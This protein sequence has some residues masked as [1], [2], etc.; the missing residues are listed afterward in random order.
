MLIIL[1][2]GLFLSLTKDLVLT[3]CI[4]FIHLN[5]LSKICTE[6][7]FK[8]LAYCGGPEVICKKLNETII[9]P[10]VKYCKKED[11]SLEVNLQPS[12]QLCQII[13]HDNVNNLEQVSAVWPVIL[14]VVYS[15]FPPVV[16]PEGFHWFPLKRASC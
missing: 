2:H 5:F 12:C 9:L 10:C 7:G 8:G 11:F 1:I 6:S 13:E 16:D 3:D 14:A 4:Q 15:I